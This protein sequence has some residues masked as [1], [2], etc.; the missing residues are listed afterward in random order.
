MKRKR[1]LLIPVLLIL[2]LSGCIR[3]RPNNLDTST[4]DGLWLLLLEL[5]SIEDQRQQEARLRR[6]DH[7]ARHIE[8]PIKQ[9]DRT[10]RP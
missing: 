5:Q 9:V 10:P 8:A 2:S 6:R 1:L 4:Q 7:L 3:V